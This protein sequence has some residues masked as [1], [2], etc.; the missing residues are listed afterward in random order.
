MTSIICVGSNELNIMSSA[1]NLALAGCRGYSRWLTWIPQAANGIRIEK[2]VKTGI[3]VFNEII[4]IEMVRYLP[5]LLY[6]IY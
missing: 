3:I 2:L 1:L 4:V 6:T 5:K